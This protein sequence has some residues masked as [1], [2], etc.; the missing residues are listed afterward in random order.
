[1]HLTE[2]IK[3]KG[4]Q[5]LESASFLN[6][7]YQLRYMGINH[8]MV[9]ATLQLRPPSRASGCNRHIVKYNLKSMA[10]FSWG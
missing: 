3:S 1:M 6:L 4:Q 5:A 9:W 8:H 2:L 7:I 10:G